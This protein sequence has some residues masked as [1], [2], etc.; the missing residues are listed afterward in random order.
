MQGRTLCR[1]HLDFGR[2]SWDT[3]CCVQRGHFRD[4]TVRCAHLGWD[5]DVFS[6]SVY[7]F[8][9]SRPVRGRTWTAS[10]GGSGKYYPESSVC[11]CV[12]VCV[13]VCVHVSAC[14]HVCYVRYVQ[15]CSTYFSVSL[16]SQP[17]SVR[18]RCHII[19]VY[20][21]TSVLTS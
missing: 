5:E 11:V 13:F 16:Y 8:L 14:A 21:D 2:R 7:Y 17:M 18:G 3:T 19:A 4:I 10:V 20:T 1:G 15:A 12:C 9:Q 6:A